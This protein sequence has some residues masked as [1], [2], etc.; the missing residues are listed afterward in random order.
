MARNMPLNW[1]I[2][3]AYGISIRQI[4][5][6]PPFASERYDIE[7]R[8]AQPSTRQQMNRMLQSL[9]EDRFHLTSHHQSKPLTVHVLVVGAAGPKLNENLDGA[10]LEIR[11][12][13]GSKTRYKNMPLPLFA[14]VL[15]GAVDDTVVDKTGLTGSYDFTLEYTAER[16]GPGV[17]DG[18]EPAP[19]PHGPSLFTAL[20]QQLGLKLER[21]K[22]PVDL[23]II[24]HVEEPSPN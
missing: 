12:I 22:Q 18:R 21:R 20:Q 4:T 10:E 9:L 11:K 16:L 24:D 17:L 13:D 5:L 14:N 2:A 6:P 3:I 23:L 15:A 1:L 8:T 7:A 19:D